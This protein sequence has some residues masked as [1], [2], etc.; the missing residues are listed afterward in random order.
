MRRWAG[1]RRGARAPPQPPR[2]DI[3]D[4]QR[5]RGSPLLLNCNHMTGS[6]S[7]LPNTDTPGGQERRSRGGRHQ[8]MVGSSVAEGAQAEAAEVSNKCQTQPLNFFKTLE[9]ADPRGW[10]G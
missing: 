5:A 9:R 4:A 2:S 1:A 7:P 8:L 3:G 10:G 6:R